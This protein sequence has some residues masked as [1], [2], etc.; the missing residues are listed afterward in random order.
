MS[1]LFV[2]LLACVLTGTA[3]PVHAVPLL[4]LL[5]GQPITAGDKVFSGW[6]LVN[7]VSTDPA[8]DP[9]LALIDVSAR[10]DPFNPG[11]HFESNG[12]LTV[13]GV[14]FIDL[15]LGFLVETLDA[16]PR[17]L[18]SSLQLGD[19]AFGGIG[20][21]ATIIASAV[22]GS[23]DTFPD[24]TV[25]A[26]NLFGLVNAFASTS[27]PLESALFVTTN[28][29]V[30]GD[31]EG[32]SVT[33]NNWEQRFSEVPEPGTLALLASGAIAAAVR[34][35]GDRRRVAASSQPAPGVTSRSST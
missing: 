8:S 22:A 24:Q 16:Q 29:L 25:F 28:L 15:Q 1:K 26:D 21:S 13:D 5:N 14:N 33:V 20:G 9:D 17:I 7:L 27:F 32:D 10:H 2:G 4:D 30:T 12:Q 3:A 6:T 34:S 35:R 18:G 23:G 31:F 19:V 11:L